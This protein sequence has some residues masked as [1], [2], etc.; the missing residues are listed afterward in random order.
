MLFCICKKYFNWLGTIELKNKMI[1]FFGSEEAVRWC[2]ERYKQRC[3][4][5]NVATDSDNNNIQPSISFTELANV[6]LNNRFNCCR[7]SNGSLFVGFDELYEFASDFYYTWKRTSR[8][9][10]LSTYNIA[11]QSRFRTSLHTA[12]LL[13]STYL[14]YRE[15]QQYWSIAYHTHF[16]KSLESLWRKRS[17]ERESLRAKLQSIFIAFCNKNL[18]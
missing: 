10:Y 2:F 18:V 13:S 16:I 12:R 9:R 14:C 7:L 8:N 3:Y 17:S 11:I 15:K 6:Q 4:A 5:P 1:Q